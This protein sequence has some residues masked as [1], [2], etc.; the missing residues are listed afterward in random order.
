MQAHVEYIINIIH[1]IVTFIELCMTFKQHICVTVYEYCFMYTHVATVSG[2]SSKSGRAA[3]NV[4]LHFYKHKD[5][6]IFN[7]FEINFFLV[8]CLCI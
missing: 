2:K 3:H 1:R 6:L 5:P 4:P 8:T 7:Q